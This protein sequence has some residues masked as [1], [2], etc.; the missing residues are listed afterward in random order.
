MRLERSASARRAWRHF[1]FFFAALRDL[2]F[3][4]EVIVLPSIDDD[5]EN[6]HPSE[7]CRCDALNHSGYVVHD[8]DCEWAKAMCPVCSGEGICSGCGG[9]GI[10]PEA[11]HV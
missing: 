10:D 2:V 9:D 4:P 7:K 11:E 1:R 6:M 3:P 8:P 5:D